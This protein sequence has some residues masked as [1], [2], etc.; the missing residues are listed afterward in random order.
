[1]VMFDE[2]ISKIKHSLK[3]MYEDLIDNNT[4]DEY[5]TKEET[6]KTA[7]VSAEEIIES[8]TK[9]KNTARVHAVG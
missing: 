1:M 7:F 4:I 3:E 9:Q 6:K 8:A 5:E 2:S